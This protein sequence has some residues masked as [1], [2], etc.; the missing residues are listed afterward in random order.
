MHWLTL[1]TPSDSL[2][3]QIVNVREKWLIYINELCGGIN[4]MFNLK[5]SE[6]SKSA[7]VQNYAQLVGK[8]NPQRIEQKIEAWL[9]NGICRNQNPC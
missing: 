8:V 9:P 7:Q 2:R 1:I 3:D 4:K 5:I 6:C